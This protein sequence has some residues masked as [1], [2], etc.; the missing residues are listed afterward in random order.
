[1]MSSVA[2]IVLLTRIVT[3][4]LVV[5]FAL[6]EIANKI[7]ALREITYRIQNPQSPSAF[8]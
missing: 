7:R 2:G 3:A 4:E 8:F 1:M 5:V 6:I